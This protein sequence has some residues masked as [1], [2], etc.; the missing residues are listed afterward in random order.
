ME[1]D[2]AKHTILPLSKFGLMQITRER[3]RP[4]IKITTA[5]QCPTCEGSGK[6]NASILLVDDIKRDLDF[7][8]KSQNPDKLTIKMH[9]FIYAY[10]KRGFWSLLMQWRWEY[11]K[12]I[13]LEVSSK[14]HML[15]YRFFDGNEDEIRLN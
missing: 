5:E 8:M 12:W 14:Y 2:N 4:A 13:K 9:P 6:V 1:D 15:K 10:L 11:R 7:I 3:V